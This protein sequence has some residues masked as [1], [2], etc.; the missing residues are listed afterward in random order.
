MTAVDHAGMINILSTILTG[1]SQD[2]S[3]IDALEVGFKYEIDHDRQ[4]STEEAYIVASYAYLFS[5]TNNTISRSTY[6][7]YRRKAKY[8]QLFLS[9]RLPINK[10]NGKP[11]TLRRCVSYHLHLLD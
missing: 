4:L 8:E 5:Q 7:N 1:G 6:E 10:K 2:Q 11:I 9:R 3:Y